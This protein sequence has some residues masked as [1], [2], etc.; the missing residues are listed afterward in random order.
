MG[1]M[2]IPSISGMIC[3]YFDFGMIANLTDVLVQHVMFVDC[4]RRAFV[5]PRMLVYVVLYFIVLYTYICNCMMKINKT[6]LVK[7][8]LE[9]IACVFVMLSYR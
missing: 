5:E 6:K 1:M 8:Y 7:K 2:G 4:W 3:Y 9:R